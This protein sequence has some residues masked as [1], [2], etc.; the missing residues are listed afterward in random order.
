M[1]CKSPLPNSK[2]VPML[3][4]SLG[5]PV[6]TP[7]L[8]PKHV[9]C[10]CHFQWMVTHTWVGTVMSPVLLRHRTLLIQP[11][12]SSYH[13]AGAGTVWTGSVVQHPPQWSHTLS[14]QHSWFTHWA[15]QNN[16]CVSLLCLLFFTVLAFLK[17]KYLSIS[18]K[19]G[20]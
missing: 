4:K 13:C 12:P 8:S 5:T 14:S 3:R 10:H 11:K 7:P 18:L 1:E 9:L 19:S 15:P 17:I 16:C 20:A 2:S 6:Y